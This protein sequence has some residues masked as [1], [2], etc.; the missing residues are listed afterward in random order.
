MHPVATHVTRTMGDT[1]ITR[2]EIVTN[3]RRGF[4]G[5]PLFTEDGT[6]L[7][8]AVVASADPLQWGLRC[9]RRMGTR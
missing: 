9:S 8:D 3:E 1:G 5:P 7:A 6:I 2:E 4:N